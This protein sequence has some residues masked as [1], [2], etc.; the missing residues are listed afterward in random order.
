[1]SLALR[2]AGLGIHVLRPPSHPT[3]TH[4]RMRLGRLKAAMNPHV[5]RCDSTMRSIND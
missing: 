4:D 3:P 5:K 2:I 1:M